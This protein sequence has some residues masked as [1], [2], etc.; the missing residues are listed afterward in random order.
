MKSYPKHKPSALYGEKPGAREELYS[1]NF[2]ANGRR[3]NW[4]GILEAQERS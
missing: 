1:P 4:E 3:R 2:D